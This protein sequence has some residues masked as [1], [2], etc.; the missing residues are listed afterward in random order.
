MVSACEGEL[1]CDFAEVYNIYD[2]RALPLST[3]AA[4]AGG[5]RSNSRARMALAGEK[6]TLS[7]ML[8]VLIFDKLSLLVWL[9]SKDGARG[10]NRPES[11][12]AKLFGT[13][14]EPQTEGFD[15]PM[16]YEKARQKILD[17]GD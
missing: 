14:N 15:D 7:E 12:A 6:H 9:N 3:A 8:G 11:L 1:I 4:L 16:A 2:H 10:K 5:L 17:G 13:P